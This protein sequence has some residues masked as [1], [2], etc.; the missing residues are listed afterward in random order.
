MKVHRQ[1]AQIQ[2]A[3][4]RD[5]MAQEQH[6]KLINEAVQKHDIAI[7]NKWRLEHPEITPDLSG[8]DLRRADLK[9]ADLQGA[10]L[11][12]ANLRGTDL[13]SAD[14]CGA[15]LRKAN[16]VL[17]HFSAANLTEA[18]FSGANLCD[19]NLS[20]ANLSEA[21]FSNSVLVGALFQG[22]DLSKA[23]LEENVKDLSPFQ[24]KAAKNWEYAYLSKGILETLGLP[25]DHNETLRKEIEEKKT[26]S[27]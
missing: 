10:I 16:L 17:A 14:L 3:R 23:K 25:P 1:A 11:T 4:S 5:T 24:I 27:P 13:S 22:S 2:G 26:A 6:S 9:K 12:N 21:N 15:D 7:W 20:E 18:D 8:M 19:A